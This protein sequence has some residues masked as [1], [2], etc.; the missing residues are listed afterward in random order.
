MLLRRYRARVLL[1][2][3]LSVR[4]EIRTSSQEARRSLPICALIFF[5]SD[6]CGAHEHTVLCI[7]VGGTEFVCV[8]GGA[9]NEQTENV[10]AF[11]IR[12]NNT[13]CEHERRR[14]DVVSDDAERARVAAVRVNLSWKVREEFDDFAECIRRQTVRIPYRSRR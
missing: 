7:F 2:V 8:D 1:R 13:V 12:W 3:R 4:T 11:C 10:A 6:E 9:A 5:D 14:A